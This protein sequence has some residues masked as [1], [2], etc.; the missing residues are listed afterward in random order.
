M[1]LT[2]TGTASALYTHHNCLGESLKQK[3]SNVVPSSLK[4]H[5][6]TSCRARHSTTAR[7]NPK[8]DRPDACFV[9]QTSWENAHKGTVMCGTAAG[10]AL[11][12]VF[13]ENT[14]YC[15]AHQ[16]GWQPL[17]FTNGFALSHPLRSVQRPG[18]CDQSFKVKIN[19]QRIMFQMV[20]RLLAIALFLIIGRSTVKQWYI[21]R[22]G[23]TV[24]PSL[25][26]LALEPPCEGPHNCLAAR[27]YRNGATRQWNMQRYRAQ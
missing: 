15:F 27:H 12:G 2:P 3:M 10:R 25:S 6:A 1:L 16:L 13:H 22:F 9:V 11:F 26:C 24:A 7:D 23:N 18:L 20:R 8:C 5:R 19:G 17:A 4:S 14:S 21:T